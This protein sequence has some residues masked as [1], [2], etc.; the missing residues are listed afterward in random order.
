MK[1]LK[2]E[3]AHTWAASAMPEPL[4]LMSE[5]HAGTRAVCPAVSVRDVPSAVSVMLPSVTSMTTNDPWLDDT[6]S[7]VW[8][9][10]SM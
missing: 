6:L 8:W 3:I 10:R 7:S 4:S 9:F 1:L 2:R 5:T